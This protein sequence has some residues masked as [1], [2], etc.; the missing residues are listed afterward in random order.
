MKDTDGQQD[1]QSKQGVIMRWN[2]PNTVDYSLRN[3]ADSVR[4]SR[5]AG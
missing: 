1:K 4:H 2:V 5:V 3:T